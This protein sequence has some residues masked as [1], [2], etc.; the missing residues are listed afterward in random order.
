M[1]GINELGAIGA[2]NE[3][4]I[5]KSEGDN[6]IVLYVN[7]NGL[8]QVG[9]H[10]VHDD[11]F[12]GGNG[13]NVPTTVKILNANKEWVDLATGIQHGA[14]LYYNIDL[15]NCPVE[16]GNK[17]VMLRV[18][19]GFASFTNIKHKNVEFGLT[20]AEVLDIYTESGYFFN[21]DG[22]MCTII[23]GDDEN[24]SEDDEVKIVA[25]ADQVLNINTINGILAT[26]SVENETV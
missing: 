3:I 18:E 5:R 24:S 14:E 9:I 25:Y 15:A 19:S 1:G 22:D 8:L 10:D 21:E 2:N 6:M 7:G 16:N 12:D 4:L 11:K 20:G 23:Y 17:V 26:S 13:N